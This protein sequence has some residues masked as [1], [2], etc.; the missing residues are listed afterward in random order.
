MA[1]MNEW[2]LRLHPKPKLEDH[3]FGQILSLL[4]Q[5]NFGNRKNIILSQ[6]I[7]FFIP[8]QMKGISSNQ[9]V[10]PI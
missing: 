6:K 9:E 4:R 5:N 2:A 3:F 7:N 8:D 10:S 1:G